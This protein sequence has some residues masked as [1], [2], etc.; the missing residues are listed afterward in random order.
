MVA[1]NRPTI[2][3]IKGVASDLPNLEPSFYSYTE[4]YIY[5]GVLSRHDVAQWAELF[6]GAEWR[7]N[8]VIVLSLSLSLPTE[9]GYARSWQ[10]VQNGAACYRDS[11]KLEA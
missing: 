1:S 9:S 6:V 7:Y 8:T 5:G 11:S 4:Q 2:I 3:G 10:S